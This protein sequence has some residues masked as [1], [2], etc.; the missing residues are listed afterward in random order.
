VWS[1]FNDKEW[2]WE[3]FWIDYVAIIIM[4]NLRFRNLRHFKRNLLLYA[5][6]LILRF[7]VT[8]FSCTDTGREK[9]NQTVVSEVRLSLFLLI[10]FWS[11]SGVSIWCFHL[12]FPSGVSIWGRSLCLVISLRLC[13]WH[14]TVSKHCHFRLCSKMKIHHGETIRKRPGFVTKVRRFS[15]HCEMV[16]FTSLNGGKSGI[17][18]VIPQT[19]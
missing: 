1:T 14:Q 11:V 16:S 17:W 9:P 13:C 19:S 5:H 10:R 3:I 18:S 4:R 8:R 12:V 6:I 15:Q 7:S 2:D